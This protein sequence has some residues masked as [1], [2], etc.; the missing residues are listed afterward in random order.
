MTEQTE[1]ITKA[2]LARRLHRS[3]PMVT[4]YCRQGLPVR[5]DGLIDWPSAKAWFE[6]NVLSERSGSFAH[7]QR[8]RSATSAAGK[9]ANRPAKGGKAAGKPSACTNGNKAD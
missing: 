9:S 3:K 4:K 5:D 8:I 2:E 6:S 7:D 1:G